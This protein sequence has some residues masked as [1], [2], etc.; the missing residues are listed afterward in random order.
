MKIIIV[1]AGDVGFHLAKMLSRE[2]QD[3]Y[4]V[5][6]NRAKLDY[7]ASHTD[8]YPIRGNCT[9]ISGLEGE[10]SAERGTKGWELERLSSEKA[11]L[12]GEVDTLTG[13]LDAVRDELKE[14]TE[15]THRL[16]HKVPLIFS[17]ISTQAQK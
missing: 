17:F 4:L 9:R 5:D 7:A 10:L 6:R 2:S 14:A 12:E 16:T 3:I 1:G 13:A 11:E 15:E 8:V